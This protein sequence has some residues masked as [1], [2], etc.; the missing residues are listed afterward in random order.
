MVYY[1]ELLDGVKPHIQVKST[2]LNYY[3]DKCN[4]KFLI[5]SAPE[6]K[7]QVEKPIISND[8]CRRSWN[9]VGPSHIC[10]FKGVGT[11]T[12]MGMFFFKVIFITFL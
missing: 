6:I 11:G 10:T 8:E 4:I 5:G 2:K 9:Q 3:E 1:P 7:Q 12:C